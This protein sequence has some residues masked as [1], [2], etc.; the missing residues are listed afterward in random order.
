M[1][2]TLQRNTEFNSRFSDNTGADLLKKLFNP[3]GEASLFDFWSLYYSLTLNFNYSLKEMAKKYVLFKN[4]ELFVNSSFQTPVMGYHSGG[5]AVK[6]YGPSDYIHYALGDITAGFTAPIYRGEGFFSDWFLSLMPHALS[7]FSQGAG[8]SK[9]VGGAVSFLYFLK[10]KKLWSLAVSSNHFLNVSY[11]R[12][13]F[14]D[15]EA[16]I[17]NL[18]LETTHGGSFIYRQGHQKYVPASMRASAGYFL[19]VSKKNI[20]FYHDLTL[21]LSFSWKM[22][23]RYYL[24]CA[25]RWK[26][27]VGVYNFSDKNIRKDRPI[28]WFE[29]GKYVFSIGGSYSF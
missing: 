5:E 27:R 13:N 20:T 9:T 22:K 7:R 3:R 16:H 1:G 14:F 4:V 12:K 17:E 19:G 24:N 28:G 11:Y 8:L 21:A 15:R 6:D 26:D 2:L 23:E 18:P 25:I 29:P 10:Q